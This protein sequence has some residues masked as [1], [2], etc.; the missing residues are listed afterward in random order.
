M[1]GIVCRG[2]KVGEQIR[3]HHTSGPD[4]TVAETRMVAV[5]E[6]KQGRF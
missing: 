5:E 6:G 4:E 3:G 1:V 2:E